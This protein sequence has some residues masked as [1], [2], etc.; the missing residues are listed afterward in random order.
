ME[1]V[2]ALILAAGSGKRMGKKI[3]KQF[4]LL[5][6]K[7][8]LYYTLEVFSN[9]KEIDEIV[10]VAKDDEIDYIRQNIVIKYKFSKV[11]KI[12]KGGAE[13]QESVLN[14]LREMNSSIVLIH[15]GARPFTSNKIIE[16]G[17]KYTKLYGGAAPGVMPKDTIKVR[18]DKG[19]SIK[20][21]DRSLLF[22]VQTPQCF[23]YE[24]ILKCHEKFKLENINST[25]DTFIYENFNNRVFLYEGSYDNIKI[26]TEEDLVLAEKILENY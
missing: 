21:L 19:F 14:G 3:N 23:I 1:K 12:V 20:T 5:K 15:D 26:T 22:N 10:L 4:I 18:D 24:K 9:C 13:R 6:N 8:I 7:P 25:D 2:T 11:V 17:I 16:D